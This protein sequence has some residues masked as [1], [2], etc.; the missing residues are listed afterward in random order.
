MKIYVVLF[1]PH[2]G[3]VLQVFVVSEHALYMLD[4]C[5]CILYAACFE[6]EMHL[7]LVNSAYGIWLAYL[8][9]PKV[10]IKELKDLEVD[11]SATR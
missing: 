4:I 5:Y 8:V 7:I 6:H 11:S 2:V 9:A 3:P 1:A 10:C